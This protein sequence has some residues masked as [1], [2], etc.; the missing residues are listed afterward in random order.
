MKKLIISFLLLLAISSGLWAQSY[1]VGAT[2]ADFATFWEAFD[3]INSANTNGDII[4]Q[5]IDNT[6]ETI[7]AV[8][9]S[10]AG[11]SNYTTIHIYPTIS[12]LSISGDVASR[13][14]ALPHLI[15]GQLVP[16]C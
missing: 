2:G 4:L 14:L 16:R 7:P 11:G 9:N 5:M 8:L 12:G 6:I 3:F 13:I 15:S 10:S 1:T